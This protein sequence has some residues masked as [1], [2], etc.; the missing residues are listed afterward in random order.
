MVLT[1]DTHDVLPRFVAGERDRSLFVD[2]L[3]RN[4]VDDLEGLPEAEIF[5]S[6]NMFD[7]VQNGRRQELP[8]GA[9]DGVPHRGV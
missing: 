8:H 5:A 3:L 2:E 6:R 9:E 1:Q 7:K 4:A